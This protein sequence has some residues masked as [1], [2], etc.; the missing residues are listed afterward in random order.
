MCL[1]ACVCA[2]N[3]DRALE[4]LQSRETGETIKKISKY[5]KILEAG[6]K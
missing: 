3:V 4:R 5:S 2:I 1:Y 6:I